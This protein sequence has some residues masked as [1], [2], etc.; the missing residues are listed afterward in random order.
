LLDVH[1]EPHGIGAASK[2][3]P[4]YSIADVRKRKV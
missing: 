1:V 3:H 4:E 2:W